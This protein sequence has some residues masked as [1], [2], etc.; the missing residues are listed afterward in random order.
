[1]NHALANEDA[2]SES[3]LAA[4]NHDGSAVPAPSSPKPK[5]KETLLTVMADGKIEAGRKLVFTY[6]EEDFFSVL[7]PNGTLLYKD[8]EF[9]SLS[10]FGSHCMKIW[11]DRRGGLD[12]HTNKKKTVDGWFGVRY[13]NENNDRIMMDKLRRNPK[14]TAR[15]AKREKK[16]SRFYIIRKIGEHLQ[17]VENHDPRTL[18]E[19]A[20]ALGFELQY[21]KMAVTDM[22]VK[23][24]TLGFNLKILSGKDATIT[25]EVSEVE[26]EVDGGKVKLQYTSKYKN[27]RSKYDILNLIDNSGNNRKEEILVNDLSTSYA[28]CRQ[29]IASLIRDGQIIG[30]YADQQ[31]STVVSRPLKYFCKLPGKVFVHRGSRFVETTMDLRGDLRRGD[32]I[33]ICSSKD[34]E[35]DTYND[36]YQSSIYRVSRASKNAGQSVSLL[37]LRLSVSCPSE[38]NKAIVELPTYQ[39][40]FN[41]SVLSLDIPYLGKPYDKTEEVFIYKF[42]VSNEIRRS[43]S[44][45][46]SSNWPVDQQA[47]IERLKERGIVSDIYGEGIGVDKKKT[48]SRKRTRKRKKY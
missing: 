35:S 7:Q 48:K 36:A 43:W 24:R 45:M 9:A 29:D 28:K 46:T 20:E 47:M 17:G 13:I 31:K 44:D 22:L 30:L 40:P 25:A 2:N 27:I 1:M 34:F 11:Q 19:L 3:S 33:R 42:G 4:T 38:Y 39:F 5:Q 6:H 8:K 32:C 21:I 10:G 23:G 26:H 15:S 12:E 37:S 14:S 41:A 18:E 16:P